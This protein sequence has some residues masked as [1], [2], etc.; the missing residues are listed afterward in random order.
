MTDTMHTDQTRD[1]PASDTRSQVLLA[2]ATRNGSTRGVASRIADRLRRQGHGVE[3]RVAEA[4]IDASAYRAVI[5]GSAVFN[6]RWLP[7]AEEFLH[8]NTDTSDTH[9]QPPPPPSPA[10]SSRDDAAHSSSCPHSRSSPGWSPTTRYGSA[11][12]GW[13]APT[14]SATDTPTRSFERQPGRSTTIDPP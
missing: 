3:F 4:N 1:T 2:Y 8:H 6:Q 12:S 14:V 9:C 7:E 5:L 13:A 11:Q 10:P